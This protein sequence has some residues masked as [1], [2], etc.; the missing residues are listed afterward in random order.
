MPEQPPIVHT[1][2]VMACLAKLPGCLC[3]SRFA[4]WTATLCF[5]RR[6]PSNQD[7]LAPGEQNIWAEKFGETVPRCCARRH[8]SDTN[9]RLKALILILAGQSNTRAGA[10]TSTRWRGKG[11]LRYASFVI[12]IFC[13]PV[14]FSWET[15]DDFSVKRIFSLVLTT[16]PPFFSK[17]RR[18]T[19]FDSLRSIALIGLSTKTTTTPLPRSSYLAPRTHEQ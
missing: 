4:Q 5:I 6:F 2:K 10:A 1:V 13:W 17:Y 7:Y 9:V 12:T 19:Q 8:Q 11:M 14:Q 15:C 16:W 3:W 18:E